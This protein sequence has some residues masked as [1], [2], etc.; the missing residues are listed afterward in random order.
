MICKESLACKIVSPRGEINSLF[1]LIIV[2]KASLGNFISAKD[3]PIQGPKF[4]SI[5]NT[6]CSFDTHAKALEYY[7]KMKEAK[8]STPNASIK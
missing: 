3:L 8:N 2:T 7:E 6:V 4:A 1:L 5:F